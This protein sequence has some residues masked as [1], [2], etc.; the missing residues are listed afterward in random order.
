LTKEVLPYKYQV[1]ENKYIKYNPFQFYFKYSQ[2]C[3]KRLHVGQRKEVQFIWNFLW[4]GMKRV[5]F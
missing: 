2:I 5:T 4:Q 1:T 3:S